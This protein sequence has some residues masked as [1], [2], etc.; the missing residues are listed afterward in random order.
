[1]SITR[2]EFEAGRT[3]KG[4][5]TK[6]QLATWGEPWPLKPGWARR[7]LGM[8]PKPQA[9]TVCPKSVSIG[10]WGKTSC[11]EPDAPE[12]DSTKH[13]LLAPPITTYRKLY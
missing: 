2:E 11:P 10:L 5:F 1:M 3:A 4:G 13:G 9:R 12:F 8:P 6:A 7:L